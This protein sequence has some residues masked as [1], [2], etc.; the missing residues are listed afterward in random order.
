MTATTVTKRFSRVYSSEWL[1]N[2][3]RYT[4]GPLLTAAAVFET[5]KCGEKIH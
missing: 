3:V 4:S 2:S 5:Q 1:V